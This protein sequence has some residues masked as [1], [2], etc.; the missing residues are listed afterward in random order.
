ML[1]SVVVHLCLFWPSSYFIF[2]AT[3][4]MAEFCWIGILNVMSVYV[5]IEEVNFD[6]TF[7]LT[8]RDLPI[9][10]LF[11]SV[12]FLNCLS[13]L[14]IGNSSPANI[15]SYLRDDFSLMRCGSVS[16]LLVWY[17]LHLSVFLSRTIRMMSKSH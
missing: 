11:D 1:S 8:S 2:A 13:R 12:S 15:L 10:S 3:R 5:A 17:S 7:K 16:P 4:G 14:S 9:W 6:L